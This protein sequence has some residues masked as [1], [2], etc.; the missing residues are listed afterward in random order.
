MHQAEVIDSDECETVMTEGLW[1]VANIM[2]HHTEKYIT[3]RANEFKNK[4][5]PWSVKSL[6]YQTWAVNPCQTTFEA[7][8]RAVLILR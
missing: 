7:I 6:K 2:E 1:S 5:K 3:R 4:H 8:Q